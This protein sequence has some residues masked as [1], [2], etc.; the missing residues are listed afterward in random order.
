MDRVRVNRVREGLH[1]S[2]VVVSVATADGTIEKLVVDYRSIED[3]TIGVGY[4]VGKRD[5]NLL[6]ELPRETSRGFWRVWVKPDNVIQ[7]SVA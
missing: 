5:G 1:P 6:V 7:E 2:E 4:P 3:D